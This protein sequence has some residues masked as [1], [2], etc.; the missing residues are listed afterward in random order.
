M[1]ARRRRGL[2]WPLGVLGAL[3]A[4][5]GAWLLVAA[6]AYSPEYVRRVLVWRESDVGDYLH[7][8]PQR[9]LTASPDPAPFDRAPDEERVRAA[10][11]GALAVS[12]L[13]DFLTESGTQALLVVKGDALLYEGYFNGTRRDSVLTSFS[14]AKSFTSALV[15]IAIDEGLIGSVDDPITEYLPELT[16]Q[17]QRL[18]DVTIRHLLL[19]SSGLEYQET[20]W[21]VFNG[22][23]ALTTYYP[24]QRALALEHARVVGPQGEVFDYNKYHPQLLGMILERTTG[25]SVTAYLQTR[26]W[27]P[28]GMEFDGAWALDSEASGFEKMEAGL[29]ATA[30]DFAKLGRVFL[31]DGARDGV[32]VVSAAW[33]RESTEPSEPMLSPERYRDDFGRVVYGGGTGYY[34]LMWYG[35][36]R[37]GGDPDFAAAGDHGQFIYVSPANDVVIVRNGTDYGIP[38]E[39]WMA[40]FHQVAGSL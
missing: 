29:N 25:T 37:A 22:D 27:D 16:D 40:A 10:F 36:M 4:V 39:E 3:V 6:V 38:H 23:D 31:A 1:V 2:V 24:D 11:E 7:H 28:A 26:L 35:V 19:M 5:V 20:R 30:V 8:F 34:A 15:G 33:V 17:D 12:E 14:V 18:T 21:A 13:D 9:A 32:P